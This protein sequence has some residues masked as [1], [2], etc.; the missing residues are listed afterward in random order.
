MKKK[1]LFSVLFLLL[2]LVLVACGGADNV[3]T[4]VDYLGAL[5]SGDLDGAALLVCP[6]RREEITSAL[7][8]VSDENRENFDFR[9][10]S[11]AARGDEVDCQYNIIQDTEAEETQEFVRN[12]VF[13][14]EDG[15][16]CGFEE[17]VAN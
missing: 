1:I 16:I 12:V 6:D 11:C 17:E 10:V 2:S 5:E 9:N 4:A 15:L 8:D 3:T 14:F 7:M 13:E